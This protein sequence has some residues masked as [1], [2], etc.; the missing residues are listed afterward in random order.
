MN[1]EV[2]ATG[3]RVAIVNLNASHLMKQAVDYEL[4]ISSYPENRPFWKSSGWFYPS[5]PLIA[6]TP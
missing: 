5:A 3:R 4:N 6:M 2:V 1:K